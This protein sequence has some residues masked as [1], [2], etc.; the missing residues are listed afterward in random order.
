MSS[1]IANTSTSVAPQANQS[2]STIKVDGT[3]PIEIKHQPLDIWSV[4][5]TNLPF[6]VTICVVS[7]SA[8]ITNC[9]NRRV[10][11]NAANQADKAR[12]AEHENK[13]SEFREKW[14]QEVRNTASELIKSLYAYQSALVISNLARESRDYANG[15]RDNELVKIHQENVQENYN[16]TNEEAP[17]F[18]LHSTKLKLLF[19]NG[20]EKTETLGN[21]E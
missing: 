5:L 11:K 3:V 18:Y 19:K 16:K 13:I 9:L 20:D 21:L 1:P 10:I 12:I 15:K 7:A 6:I 2:N 8:I 17:N 14:L 4:I